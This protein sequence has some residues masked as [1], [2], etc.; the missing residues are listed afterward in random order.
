MR[1]GEGWIWA[2]AN[3]ECVWMVGVAG[4]EMGVAVRSMYGCNHKEKF[5]EPCSWW[6]GGG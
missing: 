5:L 4:A 3:M 1:C 6:L 2:A